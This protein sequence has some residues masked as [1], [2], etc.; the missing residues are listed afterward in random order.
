MSNTKI[1]INERTGTIKLHGM[2]TEEVALEFREVL[3][4]LVRYYQHQRVTLQLHSE[5][6][7]V[8]ALRLILD[9]IYI[10]RDKKVAFAT[11]SPF[12]AYSAAA[13]LLAAGEPGYRCVSRHTSLLF[14][15]ARHQ[16]TGPTLITAEVALRLAGMLNQADTRLERI[17]VSHVTQGFG[18]IMRLAIEG[19]TRCQLLRREI[20]IVGA[21]LNLPEP[22]RLLA[23][24]EKVEQMWS[25]CSEVGTDAP[26]QEHL[27]AI[28]S[29]DSCMEVA[30][31]YALALI[32][33][34]DQVPVLLPQAA[35]IEE[36]LDQD[37]LLTWR[38][39]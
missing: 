19:L 28:F 34:V 33:K 31:A 9:T 5:G 3:D 21:Q 6:G 14:H 36:S 22:D 24:A 15:Y 7:Q 23:E 1:F 10:Y 29:K 35:R 38:F 26:Y 11:E 13:V 12:M 32:D 8:N 16:V 17:V 39:P 37:H 2:L 18:G 27:R 4:L 25:A 30:E 20:Q